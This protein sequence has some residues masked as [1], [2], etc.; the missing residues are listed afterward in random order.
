V[1]R[2]SV[3]ARLERLIVQR[4]CDVA[5]EVDDELDRLS[6]VG[7]GQLPV[8]RA[9]RVVGDGRYDAA[10]RAAIA[11]EVNVAGRGRIVFCIDEVEGG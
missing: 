6:G 3:P 4:L 1:H 8:A 10:G 11:Y 7:S 9:L 5:D 2:D